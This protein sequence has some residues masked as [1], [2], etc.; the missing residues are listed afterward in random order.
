[1]PQFYN[2]F[3]AMQ[4]MLYVSSLKGLNKNKA[5]DI[6]DQLLDQVNLI[7]YRNKKIGTFSGGMKQRLGIAQALLNNP[8]LL[9]LDEPTA[10]LDPIERIRFKN[11]ISQISTD[12]IIILATHIT[13]DVESIA[14]Q[15]LF[16]K[17][18][19]LVFDNSCEELLHSV[20]DKVW[21][22]N[23]INSQELQNLSSSHTITNIKLQS[24]NLYEAKIIGER[25]TLFNFNPATP[26]LEDAFLVY[27]NEKP[28]KTHYE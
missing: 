2:N 16:L 26:N 4:F 24:N 22:I 25:P 17:N 20:N 27:F 12:K 3:S 14:N 11:L 10:G 5:Y 15:V 1:M 9:I 28:E 19:E 7:E 21:K 8:E 23:N 13:A 6:I 18:G